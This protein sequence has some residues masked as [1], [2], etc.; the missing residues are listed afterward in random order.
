MKIAIAI[1]VKTPSLSPLKTRLSTGIGQEKAEEFYRLSVKAIEETVQE[2]EVD[3]YWAVGEKEGLAHPL[4]AGLQTLHTGDGGL[5]VRQYHVYQTLLKSYDGVLLIGADA[6]QLSKTRLQEAITRL[7]S[8]D[9]V[10][11]KAND[12]GYYLLGGRAPVTQDIWTS[13]DYS[14]ETTGESLAQKLPSS[15]VYLPLL[16]DVDTQENLLQLLNEMP[17]DLTDSQKTLVRWI[18]THI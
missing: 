4:W 10:M 17:E 3:A 15:L 16:T 7:N 14:R 12:G 13:I 5:G 18:Q 6:P 2:I 11:G 1:F 8:H 9:F